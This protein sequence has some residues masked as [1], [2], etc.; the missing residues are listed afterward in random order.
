MTNNNRFNPEIDHIFPKKLPNQSPQYYQEVDIIW[1]M[2][3]IKG[4][5]NNQKSRIH[6]REFFLSPT[7][8]KY[9]SEYDF[10]PTIDFT[11]KI[12]DNPIAF[13]NMRKK[14]MIQFLLDKYN[15][16]VEE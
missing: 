5:Y 3:P 16:S 15:L 1:N 8:S 12:Y 10:L 6:P 14:I 9:I 11:D 4:I 7:G 2:Q 13:I